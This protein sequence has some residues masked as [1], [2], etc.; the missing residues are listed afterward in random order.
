M[1]FITFLF[2]DFESMS[3]ENSF[4][5]VNGGPCLGRK[6]KWSQSIEM[7]IV[8]LPLQIFYNDFFK[9]DIHKKDVSVSLLSGNLSVSIKSTQII[10]E[11]FRNSPDPSQSTWTLEDHSMV[12]RHDANISRWNIASLYW[13]FSLFTKCYLNFFTQLR[14][15]ILFIIK[16]QIYPV[17]VIARYCYWT[18]KK[19]TKLYASCALCT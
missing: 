12:L 1:W 4:M 7:I 5:T 9:H 16:I 8:Y 18:F 11:T 15:L 3:T 13:T 2:V 17:N 6:A 10:S 19:A 14:N